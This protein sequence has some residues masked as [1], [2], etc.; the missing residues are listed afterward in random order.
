MTGPPTLPWQ[1]LPGTSHCTP[2]LQTPPFVA[3]IVLASLLFSL[4]VI[5]DILAASLCPGEAMGCP[6]N[7]LGHLLVSQRPR[8]KIDLPVLGTGWR[9]V[10]EKLDMED[11]VRVASRHIST[12]EAQ[13]STPENF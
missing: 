7:P 5:R 3:T 11:N 9:R 8:Q 1:K 12:T 13:G 10:N 4:L 2:A 6:E